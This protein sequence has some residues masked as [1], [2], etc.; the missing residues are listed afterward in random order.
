MLCIACQQTDQTRYRDCHY[1]WSQVGDIIEGQVALGLQS[2]HGRLIEPGRPS[3]TAWRVLSREALMNASMT[4][5]SAC[6][7]VMTAA[8]SLKM[9]LTRSAKEEFKHALYVSDCSSH[10]LPW[11]L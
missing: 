7:A 2:I 4:Q 9:G 6:S 11:A 1:A 3:C 10:C 5:T 8:Y